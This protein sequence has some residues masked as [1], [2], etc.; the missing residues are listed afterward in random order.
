MQV[1]E[2]RA[3]LTEIEAFRKWKGKSGCEQWA[4]V[5]RTMMDLATKYSYGK[6][7]GLLL[8][9]FVHEGFHKG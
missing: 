5:D 6:L 8:S 9:G 3:S 1:L 7:R 4:A 2:W